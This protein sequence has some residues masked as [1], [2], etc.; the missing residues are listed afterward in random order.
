[1]KIN[2][3]PK[4][5]KDPKVYCGTALL[6]GEMRDVNIECE[7]CGLCTRTYKTRAE[8]IAK[9]NEMTKGEGNDN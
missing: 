6:N 7:S 4:C 9:W 8:A 1:M 3:C 5:G 2:R